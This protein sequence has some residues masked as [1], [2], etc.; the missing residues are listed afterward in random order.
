MWLRSLVFLGLC[1]LGLAAVAASLAPLPLP[2]AR[3]RPDAGPPPD[4]DFL[5]TVAAVDAAFRAEWQSAGLEPAAPADELL[6]ARRLAL[7][8]A[9]TIPSLEEIRLLEARPPGERLAWWREGL[10][11]DPRTNDYLAERF[12]RAYVGTEDGPFLL[13]RRRRFV[14]WLSEQLANDR[15]YDALVR[16][17]ITSEGLWTDAP[18]TNFITVTIVNNQHDAQPNPN[19]LAGRVARAFLG[20]RIDCAECHDH[21]FEPW[22]QA[23]FQGLAACFSQ[24]RRSYRGIAEDPRAKAEIR[25][26]LTEAPLA[27]APR[28]PYLPD[29]APDTGNERARL[30]AWVTHPENKAFARAAVNRVWAILFGRP[31]VEPIDDLRDGDPRPA[32]MDLLA[33]DFAAHGYSLRR[34][35][36]LV[37]STEVFQLDSRARDDRPEYAVNADH[38]RAWAVFPLSRLRPEQVIGSLLQAG[39]LATL[40]AESNILVQAARAIQ[41]NQFVERYGDLGE[42]EFTTQGGTIPQRLLMMNGSLLRDKIQNPVVFNACAHTILFAPNDRAAIETAYLTVLSRRPT[43]AER[44][45]LGKLL[46]GKRNNERMRAFQDIYWALLN[47]TE[48]SWN[49]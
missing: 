19:R 27:V 8:L 13:F 2:E 47:S 41:T 24:T 38:E 44:E 42:D 29:L 31:L 34:L 6:I 20:K 26:P 33:D 45:G 32:A 49:H 11:A 43:D 18:A 4:A 21:P 15:P 36:R 22:K 39:S 46:A 3:A 17:L 40:D 25:D 23:D 37:S 28:V 10:L 48:F 35:I 7:G 5:R 12:A 1:G 9:G 30:A 16:E 14:A